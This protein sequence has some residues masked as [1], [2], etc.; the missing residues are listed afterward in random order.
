MN[1]V[2]AHFGLSALPFTREIR[3]DSRFEHPVFSEALEML[4]RVVSR[5][6]SGALIGPAGTGK[7]ALLRALLDRLPEARYRTHYVKVTDLSKRD[8]CREIAAAVDAT[9]A[10]TYPGLV[11]K[12][13]ER[14]ETALDTDSLR[15]VLVIDEAHGIR[16]DVLGVIRILTNFEMDSRLVV[17]VIL[18]GQTPLRTLLRRDSLEDV[19]RRLAC[20]MTLRPL[21]RDETRDY[22]AHR[23]TV[24]GADGLPFSP[25]ALDALFEIG[26]GNLRATDLL[27]LASLE[28]AFE[29][30]DTVVDQA[31]VTEGRRRVLP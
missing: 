5:R 19:A 16:P 28:V 13:Q 18:S 31:H 8:L 14:F 21:T 29:R 7:T 27:A 17:S 12:L 22:V 10:A 20:V 30:G 24:A 4:L 2:L 11:R 23:M 1:D 9:P 26:R 3:V 25:P 15:T 6:M